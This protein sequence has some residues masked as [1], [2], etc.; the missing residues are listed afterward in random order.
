M[1]VI[2]TVRGQNGQMRQY[3]ELTRKKGSNLTTVQIIIAIFP[4]KG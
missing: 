4:D 1:T 3:E 2:V